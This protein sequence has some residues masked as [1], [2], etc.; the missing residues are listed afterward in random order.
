M[1]E[2]DSKKIV[3]LVSILTELQAAKL[4][5]ATRLSEKFGVSTRTIYRD[6]KTLE[7]AGIPIITED[8]KGYAL[9]EGYRFPPVMLT[10]SET[11]ALVTAEKL[12]TRNTDASF[13]KEYTEAITKI[14]A[15]LRYSVKDKADLLGNRVYFGVNEAKARTSNYLSEIQHALTHHLLM[16]INYEDEHKNITSRSVEPFA[17]LHCDGNWILLAL[18]RLRQDYRFFRLDR[19]QQLMTTSTYFTPH[20]LTLMQYFQKY[21]NTSLNL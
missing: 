3:R 18:C 14:K 13:V 5:T 11:N 7:Q 4:L 19:I 17:L 21:H 2:K 9:M 12:I 10:E 1:A 8:G 20:E 16:Q 6:I 15:V